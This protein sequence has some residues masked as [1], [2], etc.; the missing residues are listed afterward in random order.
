MMP[1]Q[2]VPEIPVALVPWAEKLEALGA[3]RVNEAPEDMHLLFRLGFAE[4][5]KRYGPEPKPPKRITKR[6]GDLTPDDYLVIANKSYKI[7]RAGPAPIGHI[8]YP[9]MLVDAH[10]LRSLFLGTIHDGDDSP[11][12]VSE[13]QVARF[14]Q[15]MLVVCLGIRLPPWSKG[16]GGQRFPAVSFRWGEFE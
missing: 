15:E 2:T 13:N 5:V 12:P 14:P 3:V 16:A 8:P 6:A 4:K 11:W 10:G 9:A 7:K 1:I